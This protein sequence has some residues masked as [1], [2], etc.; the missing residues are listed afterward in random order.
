MLRTQNEFRNFG[1]TNA[2]DHRTWF[3][4]EYRV[5]TSEMLK[6]Q[7]NWTLP[8]GSSRRL[9]ADRAIRTTG[10][11]TFFQR[12]GI[13]AGGRKRAIVAVI[14]QTNMLAMPEFDETPAEIEDEIK[15]GNYQS[16]RNSRRADIPLQS[17]LVIIC[18]CIQICRA[19]IQGG[20]SR[21]FTG[22][23]PRRGRAWWWCS[24]P[25][26]LARLRGGAICFSAWRAAFS[27]ASVIL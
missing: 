15:I 9:Y 25:F 8:D 17:H 2:R 19:R 27:F 11:W 6:P 26:R 24:S 4:A 22:G 23:W 18:G 13:F 10:V 1:F 12:I 16:L 20:C 3:I 5:K 21:N 7:V 14:L